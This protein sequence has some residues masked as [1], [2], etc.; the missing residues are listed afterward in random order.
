MAVLEFT[1]TADAA[2]QIHDILTCLSK[3]SDSVYIEGRQ[4]WV[5]V[6][7]LSNS[8]YTH[9]AFSLSYRL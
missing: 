5:G 6:S 3:F 7:P 8:S 2:A 9:M 4:D 1:L